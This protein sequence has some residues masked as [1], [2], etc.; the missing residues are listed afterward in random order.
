M[1]THTCRDK[2]NS[3]SMRLEKWLFDGCNGIDVGVMVTTLVAMEEL[4][5]N[6]VARVE[7][8]E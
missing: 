2:K 5:S 4:P 3:I 7:I 6:K 8:L 1:S